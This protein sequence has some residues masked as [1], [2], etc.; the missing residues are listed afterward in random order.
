MRVSVGGSSANGPDRLMVE[1]HSHASCLIPCRT[2]FKVCLKEYQSNMSAVSESCSY[3]N[4]S[5]PILGGNSFTLAD[6]D[7]ANGKLTIRF[8]FSWTVRRYF[9]IYAR[10]DLPVIAGFDDRTR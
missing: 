1:N 9:V 10:G 8:K 7:R 6:P 3:G 5:S 4:A 2:F